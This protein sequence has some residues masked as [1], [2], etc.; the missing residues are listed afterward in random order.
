NVDFVLILFISFVVSYC[1]VE[2][3]SLDDHTEYAVGVIYHRE[4]GK[5]SGNYYKFWV[6]DNVYTGFA[7]VGPNNNMKVGDSLFVCYD[8]TNP[9][10]NSLYSYFIYTLDRSKLPDTVFHRQLVDSKRR[11]WE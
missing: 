4:D 9:K 5:N 11:P 2:D 7:R 10:N 6:G 3:K 8:Y 1:L